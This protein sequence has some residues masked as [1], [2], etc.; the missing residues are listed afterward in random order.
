MDVN[1]DGYLSFDEAKE[2]LPRIQKQLKNL[3]TP[4]KL[5]EYFDLI[6]LNK[7]SR[8]NFE[9]FH[10]AVL[11]QLQKALTSSNKNNVGL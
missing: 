4:E 11:T 5:K 1:N 6:D 9:E 2:Y 8:I 10:Q 3:Q 7:D